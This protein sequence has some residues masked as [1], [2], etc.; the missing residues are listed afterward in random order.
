MQDSDNIF[1]L[2]PV[3]RIAI[4]QHIF[5]LLDIDI[6]K[7]RLADAKKDTQTRINILSDDSR[8]TISFREQVTSLL[9]VIQSLPSHT[10]ID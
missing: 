4:L 9:S 3:K 10:S 8:I 1:M 2:T 7:E 5:R 6:A